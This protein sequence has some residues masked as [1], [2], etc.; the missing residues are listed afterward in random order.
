[1]RLEWKHPRCV[2]CLGSEELSLEHVIPDSL[3]GILTSRFLCSECNSQFGS[4]FEAKARLAPELRKAAS[5]LGPDLTHLK[6]Q[7]ERGTEYQS[8]FDDQSSKS[9]VRKDGK[10][11][12]FGLNEPVAMAVAPLGAL[13][14]ESL[15]NGLE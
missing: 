9:K 5:G 4:T 10:A 1:M 13:A 14:D 11:G 6:E 12:V 2:A 8:Q 15:C 3:G 7:L